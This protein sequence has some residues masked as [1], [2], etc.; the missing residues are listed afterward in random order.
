MLVALARRFPEETD[1]AA[2]ARPLLEGA[3]RQDVT[4]LEQQLA[5]EQLRERDADRAY[6]EPL[7]REREDLRRQR[8]D[9]S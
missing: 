4:S 8:R 6:W 5:E 3:R 1:R 7:K 9:G 2:K